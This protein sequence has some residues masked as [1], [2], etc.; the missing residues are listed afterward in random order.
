MLVCDSGSSELVS[1]STPTRRTR[2]PCARAA[3]G[4]AAAPTPSSVMNS[5][6]LMSSLSPRIAPYHIVV[7]MPRCASQQIS[8]AYARFGSI[9]SF[10][11]RRRHDRFTPMNGH[12][13]RWLARPSRAISDHSHRNKWARYS[14]TS[15]ARASSEMG[16]SRPSA[17][18]AFELKTNR[19]VT[20]SRTNRLTSVS[21]SICMVP[22]FLA[23][24]TMDD[25][26]FWAG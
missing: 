20:R 8:A 14:I 24:R 4:H 9:A 6:R 1:M 2:S 25:H 7:G 17:S 19:P 13:Q 10:R 11:A 15:S 21:D 5:R 23:A 26:G 22:P 12:I 16:G 3:S 18:I